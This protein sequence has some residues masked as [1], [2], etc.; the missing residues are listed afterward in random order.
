MDNSIKHVPGGHYVRTLYDLFLFSSPQ[1]SWRDVQHVIVRSARPAPGGV[2]LA[3]GLWLK[4]KAGLAVSRFYGFGLMDA[5]E[6]VHLAKQWNTVPEQRTCEVI[7]TDTNR[8]FISTL[9][10]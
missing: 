2:P 10:L 1:L 9:F 6:M 3:K 5:G 4:N 7:G 8:Y